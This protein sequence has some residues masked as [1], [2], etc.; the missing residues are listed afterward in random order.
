MSVCIAVLCNSRKDIVTVSD[1]KVGFG[2][3]SADNLASKRHHGVWAGSHVLFAGNDIEHVLP[4]LDRAAQ[5]LH[6]QNEI[7]LLK[8][9]RRLESAKSKKA[10]PGPV[11]S[12][13]ASYIEVVY[14]IDQA[15]GERLQGEITKKVLRK[16]GF[17]VNTFRDTGKEKYT[18]TA[19]LALLN[20]I[21][22]IK[23]SLKFIVCGFDKDGDGHIYSV[24]GESSPK[25]YDPI[26]MWAIG[27]GA[28]AALSSLAFHGN[29]AALNVWTSTER[30]A[31]FAI[32]AKFMAESSSEVGVG[33][34]DV[35]INQEGGKMLRIPVRDIV[36]IRKLWEEQGAPRVPE[37]LDEIMKGHIK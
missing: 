8:L 10:V 17:D 18:P 24:D 28:H 25:C 2:D 27:S 5:I 7:T 1:Y 23:I 16:R 37:N 30:A 31:Y 6:S 22:Q 3:F 4:I 14:A 33:A 36:I 34:T 29:Q 15:Y 9:K 19:Y 26:G 32:A 35:Y 20:R 11:N 21:D 12:T 13:L